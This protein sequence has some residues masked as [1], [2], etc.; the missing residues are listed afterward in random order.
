MG[1]LVN[2]SLGVVKLAG[3]ILGGSFALISD[4]VNSLGDSLTSIV[5]LA[6]LWYAQRPPD[7][8]HPYGH[9][10]AEA[11]AASNVALL[12]IVSGL[13]VGWEALNRLL[14][15]HAIPPLWTLAIAAANVV[16][17]EGLYRYKLRVSRRTRSAAILANAWDHRSDALCSLAVLVGLGT[18]RWAGPDYLWADEAAALV[19]VVAILW[20]GA[21]LFRTS[22]S[23]LLDPQ[24]DADLV[25]KIRERA[26]T[27]PGVR[28]VEKLWVRKT[29]LEYLADI[30]IQVDAQLSVDEGHR[31]GH[32]VKDRL[33]GEFAS[34]RDVLVH[35][36]PYPHTHSRSRERH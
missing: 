7:D 23:E 2:L 3:G 27:V 9:T 35:L 28:A 13:L 8:E 24:A 19:V 36:E 17:K 12:I 34:L 5:V 26:E 6:G 18:V 31:I 14:V 30:H 10:R 16:I 25:R 15:P 20:S 21:R 29:G 33:V 1:L 11:V 32:D 4:A 22:T